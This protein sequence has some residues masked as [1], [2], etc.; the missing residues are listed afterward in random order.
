M[1]P[2]ALGIKEHPYGL[3]Q[4]GTSSP[5]PKIILIK[6]SLEILDST[7]SSSELLTLY[8]LLP[9]RG[10]TMNILVLYYP[11]ACIPYIYQVP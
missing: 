7:F 9:P 2:G 8:L 1:F 5:E 11:I 10:T 4:T 3:Y 6:V